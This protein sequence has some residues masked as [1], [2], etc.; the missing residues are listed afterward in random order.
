MAMHEMAVIQD[1]V[2]VVVRSAEQSGAKQVVGI[3]L[4]VGEM[5]DFVD[6][7]M[8]RFFDFASRNTIAEGAKL[9]VTRTPIVFGCECG[10]FF[11]VS[12]EDIRNTT[13]VECPFCGEKNAELR[14]GREFEIV[15][16]EV[17]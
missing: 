6:E 5:R 9:K 7:W 17:K 16:I 15:S 10:R 11:P 8:Q 14:S 1:V 13:K 3:T 2:S 4:K 12:L